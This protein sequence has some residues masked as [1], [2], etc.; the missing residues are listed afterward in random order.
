MKIRYLFLVIIFCSTLSQ[1]NSQGSFYLNTGL[2]ISKGKNGS[3]IKPDTW[4]RGHSESYSFN[5]SLYKP[6]F[7]IGLGVKSSVEKTAYI[8]FSV[9]FQYLQNHYNYSGKM[10]DG[11][12]NS[13][14]F[15]GDVDCKSYYIDSELLLN[16]NGFSINKARIYIFFGPAIGIHLNTKLSGTLI[17]E[18]TD[19]S[20]SETHIIKDDQIRWD[21]HDVYLSGVF[22]CGTSLSFMKRPIDIQFAYVPAFTDLYELPNLKAANFNLTVSIQL[23][24]SRSE[25]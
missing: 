12:Y 4:G 2:I 13:Y 7:L 22:G 6:G 9:N 24:K 18:K 11:T 17:W 5:S 8:S 15:D 1:G 19:Y 14:S 10:H 16:L 20:G 3:V 23:T 21:P 25:N